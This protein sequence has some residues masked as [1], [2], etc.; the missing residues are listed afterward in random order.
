MLS[1]EITIKRGMMMREDGGD[2]AGGLE[3]SWRSRRED[4]AKWY[5][6]FRGMIFYMGLEESSEM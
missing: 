2:W 4:Q 6:R 3:N 5:R 1:E